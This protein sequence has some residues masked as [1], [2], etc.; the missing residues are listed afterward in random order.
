VELKNGGG[1]RGRKGKGEKGE[2]G[3]NISKV[4]GQ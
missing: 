1:R 3:K 4:L 2:L